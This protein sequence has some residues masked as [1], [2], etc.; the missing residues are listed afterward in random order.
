MAGPDRQVGRQP[1]GAMSGSHILATTASTRPVSW[2][3]ADSAAGER[4]IPEEAAIALV[5]DATTTA[6][7]M[8]S[9]AD[10]EDFAVGFSLT[11]RIVRHARDIASLEV[12]EARG[13]VEVRAWL[14]RPASRTLAARRRRAAGPTGCGLCGIDSLREASRP[15]P[16]VGFGL[17][18]RA[19]DIHRALAQLTMGQDLGAATRATHAAAWWTPGEGILALREDVGRHNALDK[20]IGALARARV[21]IPAGAVVLTSRVS[22]EMVQ[23]AAVAG[24]QVVIAVSAPT[25]LAV[26][27]AARAN[28]T[29]V[30]IA[31]ADGFE[32]FTHPERVGP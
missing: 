26:R 29:L 28:M 30:A 7:M 16:R 22:V 10:L 3:G 5:H 1:R 8:A 6:V 18:L 14:A 13:G 23:K 9:P 20:T 12:A 24:A 25:A 27:T 21:R 15:P 17:T 11:E 32:V 31:R 2:R 19:G 4:L